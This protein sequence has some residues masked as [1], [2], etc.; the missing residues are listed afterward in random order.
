MRCSLLVIFITFFFSLS[1]RAQNLDEKELDDLIN[2]WEEQFKEKPDRESTTLEKMED[3]HDDISENISD[4]ASRIDSF[5]VNE[6]VVYGRNTTN[7]RVF[8]TLSMIESEGVG[9]DVDFKVRL[10]LPRLKN[11]VQ[12]EVERQLDDYSVDGQQRSNTNAVFNRNRN[13]SSERTR[14]GFSLFNDV[15]TIQTK[16][17]AG[18]EYNH[19]A[20]PYT[21]L[22]V[23]KDFN[24]TKTQSFTVIT[25]FFAGVQDKTRQF[26][27]TYY[28]IG[29]KKNSF[30]R[31]LNEGTYKDKDRTYETLHA[32]ILFHELNDRNTM[33]YTAALRALNPT[34]NSTFYASEYFI[35]NTLRHRLYKRYLFLETSPGLSWPKIKDFHSVW[36]ITLRL[37]VIFGNI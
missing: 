1:V 33:S 8:N 36:Q 28:N 25:N 17:T 26:T 3:L 7:I 16:V 6:N 4:L 27:T 29:I 35:G 15:K 5:F 10:Q 9:G 12:F 11:K 21:N 20:D 31:I 32:F 34:D 13:G 24:F 14:A 18:L 22:R 19:G 2:D 37:E 30:F 23:S